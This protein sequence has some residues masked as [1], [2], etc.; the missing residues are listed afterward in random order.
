MSLRQHIFQN[1]VRGNGLSSREVTFRFKRPRIDSGIADK[2]D[3]DF[4]QRLELHALGARSGADL[5]RFHNGHMGAWHRSK[6]IFGDLSGPVCAQTGLVVPTVGRLASVEDYRHYIKIDPTNCP[7]CPVGGAKE[8]RQSNG[9]SIPFNGIFG[10]FTHSR[11]PIH[12]QAVVTDALN[13]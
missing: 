5:I 2:V 6:A 7:N 3:L 10:P 4:H 9:I 1:G 13:P 11:K 8:V 12:L